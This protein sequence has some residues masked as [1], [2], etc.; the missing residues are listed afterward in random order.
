MGMVKATLRWISNLP[1]VEAPANLN[2]VNM[3]AFVSRIMKHDWDHISSQKDVDKG[4]TSLQASKSTTS[5]QTSKSTESL[6]ASSPTARGSETWL[7][8]DHSNPEAP[9]SPLIL[10][11]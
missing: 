9:S 7:L 1:C 2:R 3:V 8:A 10:L 4:Q 6:Q 11:V 5:S